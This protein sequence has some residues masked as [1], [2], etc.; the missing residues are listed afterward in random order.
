MA[1]KKETADVTC[2]I[3]ST[4]AVLVSFNAFSR[5]RILA[6]FV[7]RVVRNTLYLLNA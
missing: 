7:E 4:A 5:H 6:H 3:P 1:N 2:D